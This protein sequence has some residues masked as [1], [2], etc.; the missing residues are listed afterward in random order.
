MEYIGVITHLLTIDPNFLG[1]PSQQTNY[2][3]LQYM[4][5]LQRFSPT[6]FY[7]GVSMIQ[8]WRFAYLDPLWNSD[9]SY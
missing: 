6:D 9:W 8:L 4:V 7:P 3:Y 1:H 2:G 5:E